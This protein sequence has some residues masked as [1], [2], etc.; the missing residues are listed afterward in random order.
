MDT[1]ADHKPQTAALQLPIR[2]YETQRKMDDYFADDMH[3]GDI[4][5]K[6][7]RE[8][9]RLRDIS[10]RINP[11]TFPNRL[12]SARILFDEFRSLSTSLS[13]V[14]E[15]QSLIGKL[16]DHMQ[17]GQGDRFFDP[18]LDAALENH[19]SMESSLQK[20]R[21]SLTGYIN[22]NKGYLP[23]YRASVI[24]DSLRNSFL[25]KFNN[26]MD[27]INGLGISVHDTWATH[28]T[29]ESLEINGPR[30][31]AQVHYR[32]QDHFGLD[33]SDITDLFFR[34]F[35]IFRIWF[36][37]QRWQGYGYQPFIT[38][39]NTKKIIEGHRDDKF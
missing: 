29:L 12:E 38:E 28:I 36:T 2:I 19:S 14:G 26:L 32:I 7:L 15:Y 20:I 25:P 8:R 24:T 22:W 10:T 3:Y 33:D 11:F 23:Q 18:M 21:E 9:Y 17:Y 1:H 37:L 16:I 6:V 31:R 13:F 30:Y 34:Q 39:M 4:S 5:E 35:R 27:R